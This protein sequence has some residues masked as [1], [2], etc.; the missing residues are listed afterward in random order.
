MYQFILDMKKD[1]ITTTFFSFFFFASSLIL[2]TSI[3]FSSYLL[4]KYSMII[5]SNHVVNRLTRFLSEKLFLM[6]RKF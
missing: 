5:C 3:E 1:L 6:I 4:A 2:L